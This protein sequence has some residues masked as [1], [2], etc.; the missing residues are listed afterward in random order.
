MADQGTA[1]AVIGSCAAVSWGLT[2]WVRHLIEVRE[3]RDKCQHQLR[4]DPCFGW[5]ATLRC[6]KGCGYQ[7]PDREYVARY[8][9]EREDRIHAVAAR[10]NECPKC[11]SQRPAEADHLADAQ[12]HAESSAKAWRL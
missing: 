7:E 12:D 4:T 10:I 8:H 6:V 1:F 2:V 9:Q 5:N 3:R 11:G